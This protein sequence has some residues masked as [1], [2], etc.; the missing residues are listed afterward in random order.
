MFDAMCAAPIPRRLY[1]V[2]G[3]SVS[4]TIELPELDEGDATAPVDVWID[5]G[6]VTVPDPGTRSAVTTIGADA[7]MLAIGDVGRF[8]I[9]DGQ[10]ITVAS[11]TGASD[12]N[13]RL[14]LL[15]SAMGILLHQRRILPLH[16][17]AVELG[18]E[19]VA[20]LG[21]PGAGKS[22]LA[23]A[24]HDAGYRVLSDDV[25]A[26]TTRSDRFMVEPGIPR[27]R[28][29]RD[30]LERS[31]RV[32]DDHPRAFDTLD[33]Y[34]VATDRARRGVALPLRAVYLLERQEAGRGDLSIDRLTGVAAVRALI[35]NTYR[36]GYISQVG[37]PAKHVQACAA[38]A[39]A[40]PV[41]RLRRPWSADAIAPSI[42]TLLEHA[43]G[44]PAAS[45]SGV[46]A[47]GASHEAR[48]RSPAQDRRTIALDHGGPFPTRRR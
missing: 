46:S 37:D 12:A 43:Q 42:A 31:G 30:A 32:V 17:N 45:I 14:F 23:A 19:A 29:W 2:F 7:F 8:L 11:A 41:Y 24:F 22:T 34:T 40:V 20:F 9:Q 4:S 47:T 5:H 38:L 1:R 6:A 26:I 33:K 39:A 35:E 48:D 18:D 25:C 28:L 27:L 3:L 21:H 13:V 36:G 16:A 44:R 10:M 15:G